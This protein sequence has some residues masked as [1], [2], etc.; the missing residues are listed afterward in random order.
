MTIS[1]LMGILQEM[2][3]TEDGITPES[4]IIV[5]YYKRHKDDE[6]G[7]E[8]LVKDLHFGVVDWLWSAPIDEEDTTKIVELR[9]YEEPIK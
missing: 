1:E 2:L 8:D 6:D 4:E 3:Y 5:S 9:A 7:A